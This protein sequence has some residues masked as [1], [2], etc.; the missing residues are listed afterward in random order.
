MAYDDKTKSEVRSLMLKTY[1]GLDTALSKWKRDPEGEDAWVKS[2]LDGA[3]KR[4]S[5]AYR[6]LDR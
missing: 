5:S 1:E 6:M 2:E 3:I 4:L